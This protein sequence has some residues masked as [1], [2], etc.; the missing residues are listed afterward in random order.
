MSGQ[1]LRAG[2]ADEPLPKHTHVVLAFGDGR[3]LR[4]VDPRTF[5]ELFVTEPP[6]LP[7]LA[8]LGP[9]PSTRC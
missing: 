7:E 9:T 4:F 5:G 8:H 3:Q 6:T 2:S 1:L